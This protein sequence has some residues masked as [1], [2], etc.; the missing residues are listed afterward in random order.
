MQV[1]RKIDHSERDVRKLHNWRR[2]KAALG[3]EVVQ[4]W[5]IVGGL[6]IDRSARTRHNEP[7]LIRRH[8]FLA[9]LSDQTAKLPIWKHRSGSRSTFVHQTA[10][11]PIWKLC[12]GIGIDALYRLSISSIYRLSISSIYKLYIGSPSRYLWVLLK[13]LSK[14]YIGSL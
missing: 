11:F 2:Q 4:K 7:A 1:V 9:A 14:L 6:E 10:G 5:R 13:A 12:P 3:L 8:L